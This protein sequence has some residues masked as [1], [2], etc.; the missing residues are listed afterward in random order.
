MKGRDSSENRWILPHSPSKEGNFN[1]TAAR[2][3]C[4]ESLLDFIIPFPELWA[5]DPILVTGVNKE[6]SQVQ[7]EASE[8]SVHSRLFV[9]YLITSRFVNPTVFSFENRSRSPGDKS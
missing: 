9:H 2:I 3:D 7:Q 5:T 1:E 8:M 4:S 6:T